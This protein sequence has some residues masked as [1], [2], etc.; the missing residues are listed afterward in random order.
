MT[1]PK[2]P[3]DEAER[4][5]ASVL[6]SA[7]VAAENLSNFA[8]GSAEC[9]VCPVCRAIAAAREPNPQVAERLATGA[10]DLASGVAN[11][12]RTMARAASDIGSSGGSSRSGGSGEPGSAKPAGTAT[13]DPWATATRAAAEAEAGVTEKPAAP[14]AAEKPAPAVPGATERPAAPGAAEPAAPPNPP[15]PMAKKAVK[16]K[17]PAE[18]PTETLADPPAEPPVEPVD[19]P[20]ETDEER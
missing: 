3:R 16:P 11:L 1:D 19:T 5:I 20:S 10:G 6:G 4:L 15:R 7:S 9:C 18:P 17:A 2:D 14:G 8:T 13:E 12:L